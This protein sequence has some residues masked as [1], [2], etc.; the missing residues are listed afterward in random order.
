MQ[1]SIVGTKFEDKTAFFKKL[2]K[3]NDWNIALIWLKHNKI[4]GPL[5]KLVMINTCSFRFYDIFFAYNISQ[6]SCFFFLEKV[7]DVLR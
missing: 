6:T 1:F 4:S 3:K 5:W 2:V 7:A